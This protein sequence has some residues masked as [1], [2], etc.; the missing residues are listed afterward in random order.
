MRD[1]KDI[2]FIKLAYLYAEQ[3]TCT[4]R[5]VG[6]VIVRDDIQLSGGYNGAPSK[7]QHCNNETCIR[8]KLNIPSGQRHEMCR[9]SHAEI[10]AISQAARNGVNIDNSTMYCTTQP[11]IYCA[12][13]MVNAGIKRLVYC[14]EYGNGLDD[15]TQEMLKNIEIIKIK[16]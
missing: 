2:F 8:K 1:K 4:R 9:G 5:K 11:C 15:L 16:K 7:I 6:C 10:N 3:S 13:A 12:K 14:E